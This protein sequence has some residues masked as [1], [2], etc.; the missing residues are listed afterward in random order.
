MKFKTTLFSILIVLSSGCVFTQNSNNMKS[1]HE[2]TRPNDKGDYPI[3]KSKE[4]WKSILEPMQYQVLREAATER[5]Y[6]GKYY[7]NN[8]TGIYYSAASGQ[9]LFASDAKYDSGCGW[10]SFFEPIVEG[11]ILYREDR[12]MGMIRTEI[13]DSSTGSH[14]GHVFDDGPKPTGLRYCMNSAAM[15][16]VGIN[17]EHPPLVKDYMENHA[18]E[19]E[20]MAVK[21]FIEAAK[22]ATP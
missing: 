9:P 8:S 12:T 11:A 14:L 16:F 3:V 2:M 7:D 13:I 19:E 4:E 18:T 5:P 1:N 21:N 15:I 17:D 6:T 20:K 10:P 22:E